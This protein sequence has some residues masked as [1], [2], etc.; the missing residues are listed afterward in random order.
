M[1]R[2]IKD[3]LIQ[4]LSL[5]YLVPSTIS[6]LQTFF[7]EK[8]NNSRLSFVDSLNDFEILYIWIAISVVS[9]INI[10]IRKN[11]LIIKLN[12]DIDI[13]KQNTPSINLIV[14]GDFY[15]NIDQGTYVNSNVIKG[16]KSTIKK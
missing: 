9:G 13:V 3:Y 6:V 7:S 12:A 10:A 4:W 8:I 11:K 16:D 14:N 15:A 2:A 1:I 5:L